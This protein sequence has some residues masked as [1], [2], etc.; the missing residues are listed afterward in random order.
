MSEEKKDSKDNKKNI[1]IE[2][3]EK[4]AQGFY[5]NLAMSNFSTEEFILDF[6]FLQPQV[7]KGKIQS[8]VILSPKNAKRL[9][10]MLMNNIEEFEKKCGPIN[11]EPGSSGSGIQFSI[12]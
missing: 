2:C 9:C 11:D 1:Q 10:K 8:R 7:P 12:N 6:V 4:V 5:S 3:D